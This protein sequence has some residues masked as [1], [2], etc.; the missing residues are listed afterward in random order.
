MSKVTEALAKKLS[1]KLD[2]KYLKKHPT[3]DYLTVINP[4]GVVERLN[5][6]FGVGAWQFTTEY[7]DCC[8]TKT[9]AGATKYMG[10]V[11]GRVI[12]P[13]YDIHIEQY[14]G[15]TND[16]MGDALKGSATDALTKCASYLDVAGYI[17]RGEIDPP[18]DK[19][20]S[21][22]ADFVKGVPFGEE[23]D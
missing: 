5:Q 10:V 18:K 12:V 22:P 4:M 11:I 7:I 14:G 3:K 2:E 20:K 17:Y 21:Y 13:E 1:E 8:E 9:R 6:V 19:P 15:S 23:E 16:D